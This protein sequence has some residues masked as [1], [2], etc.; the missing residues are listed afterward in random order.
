MKGYS[1]RRIETTHPFCKL[2]SCL[3]NLYRISLWKEHGKALRQPKLVVLGRV[4]GDADFN[5][6]RAQWE[7][8][9][10]N[11]LLHA[12]RF[13]GPSSHLRNIEHARLDGPLGGSDS[14][15]ALHPHSL[16]KTFLPRESTL[17]PVNF[18]HRLHVCLAAIQSYTKAC[19]WGPLQV[20][21]QEVSLTHCGMQSIA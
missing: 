12:S 9:V 13:P 3:T 6:R 20:H 17:G 15:F 7:W 2:D 10:L 19:S 14:S 11:P 5:A 16:F 8:W 21:S 18:S 1:R 4:Q